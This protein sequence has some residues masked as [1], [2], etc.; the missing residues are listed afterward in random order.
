MNNKDKIGL[1]TLAIING[2]ILITILVPLMAK[3]MNGLSPYLY[4]GYSETSKH[5]IKVVS[6]W[7]DKRTFSNGDV[8]KDTEMPWSYFVI[9]IIVFLAYTSPMMFITI[10]L[11]IKLGVNFP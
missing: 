11:Y 1:F 3:T 6:T 10:R 7:G 2:V 9:F 8:V 4:Y 5:N